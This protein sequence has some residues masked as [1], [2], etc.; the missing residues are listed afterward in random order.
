MWGTKLSL[1]PCSWLRVWL[2]VGRGERRPEPLLRGSAGSGGSGGELALGTG[3]LY[4][5]IRGSER[6]AAHDAQVPSCVLVFP[7]PCILGDPDRGHMSWD[8]MVRPCLC[9][10]WT[11]GSWDWGTSALDAPGLRAEPFHPGPW[12]PVPSAACLPWVVRACMLPQLTAEALLVC[13]P[14]PIEVHGAINLPLKDLLK[15]TRE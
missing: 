8:V 4:P 15:G 13:G 14:I 7:H 9:P 11:L 6:P 5:L 3:P 1:S 2:R 10:H 12:P